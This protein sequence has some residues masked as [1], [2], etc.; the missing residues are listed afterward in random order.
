MIPIRV[1][2]KVWQ[3][4]GCGY[5]L[6]GWI[7]NGVVDHSCFSTEHECVPFTIEEEIVRTIGLHLM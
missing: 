4:R 6:F 5:E 2:A 1:W 3:C 7:E